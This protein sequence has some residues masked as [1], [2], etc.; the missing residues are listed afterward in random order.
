ML[1]GKNDCKHFFICCCL[2]CE[3]CRYIAFVVLCYNNKRALFEIKKGSCII[4]LP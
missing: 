1:D 3:I 4:L 2:K